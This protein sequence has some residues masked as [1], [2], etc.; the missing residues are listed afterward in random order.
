MH[1]I[2]LQNIDLGKPTLLLII[3]LEASSYLLAL[4]G[5]D[6]DDL[7]DNPEDFSILCDPLY[8]SCYEKMLLLLVLTKGEKLF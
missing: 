2:L 7:G 4:L 5:E 1:P 6:D 3:S 8:E